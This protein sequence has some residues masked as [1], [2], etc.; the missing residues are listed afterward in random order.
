MGDSIVEM[1]KAAIRPIE[2]TGNKKDP[3]GNHT[4]MLEYAIGGNVSN[5]RIIIF[6][7]R[8]TDDVGQGMEPSSASENFSL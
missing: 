4:I 3:I 1:Q 8:K 7:K 6:K 5:A 2:Q